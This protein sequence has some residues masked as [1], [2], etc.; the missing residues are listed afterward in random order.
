MW[1]CRLLLLLLLDF[2][3]QN[4]IFFRS[5]GIILVI[6]FYGLLSLTSLNGL[7]VKFKEIRFG[8][9]R[10]AQHTYMK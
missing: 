9:C 1:F 5:L 6:L 10:S 7:G 8:S 3:F 2:F 4:F